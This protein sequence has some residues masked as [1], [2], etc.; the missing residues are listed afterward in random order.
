MLPTRGI[1]ERLSSICSPL[2]SQV[3]QGSPLATNTM[4]GIRLPRR[5]RYY[6]LVP[7]LLVSQSSPQLPPLPDVTALFISV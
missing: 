4:G 1:R 7:L 6:Q 5:P 2:S 3:V